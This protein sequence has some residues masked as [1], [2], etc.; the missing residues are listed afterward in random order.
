[1]PKLKLL[2]KEEKYIPF[3]HSKEA[4]TVLFCTSRGTQAALVS[5]EV[6]RKGSL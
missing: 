2:K 1:L 5:K 4:A 6:H 3:G